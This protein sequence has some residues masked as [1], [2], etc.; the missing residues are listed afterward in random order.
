MEV[1][2][3]ILNISILMVILALITLPVQEPGSGSFIVNIMA[4][5]SSLALL[6]L[7]IYIIKRK[8]LSTG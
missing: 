6:A 3:V 1:A 7:S 4:L 2:R 5:V 8:L